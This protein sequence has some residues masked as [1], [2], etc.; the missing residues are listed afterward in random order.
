MDL[1]PIAS[2]VRELEHGEWYRW[3]T[4]KYASTDNSWSRH[5]GVH[6]LRDVARPITLVKDPQSGREYYTTEG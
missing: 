2:P 6:R 1:V 5:A 4:A 3:R